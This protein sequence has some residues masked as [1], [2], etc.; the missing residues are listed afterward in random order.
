[1]HTPLASRLGDTLPWVQTLEPLVQ[2]QTFL[3]FGGSFTE[4]SADLWKELRP[5]HQQLVPGVVQRYVWPERWKQSY[6]VFCSS[7]FFLRKH[8]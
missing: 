6:A 5:E 8:L 7:V 1:M 2:F 4:S 3:G